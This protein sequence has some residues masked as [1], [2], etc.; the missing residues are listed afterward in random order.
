MNKT[1]SVPGFYDALI[2][3]AGPAG[4]SAAILLAKAGWRVLVVEKTRFPRRKVCGEYI[5]GAA[6]PL[7]DELGVGARIA[8]AA[9]PEIRRVG[10]FADDAVVSSLMPSHGLR[11]G[12]ALGREHLDTM[13][14]QQARECGATVLEGTAFDPAHAQL[15]H[16]TIA[17]HGAW[18]GNELATSPAHGAARTRDLL[19]F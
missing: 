16:V 1:G 15:A 6:W 18:E 13:L 3:G 10:L 9:G 19:G 7:L 4:S 17:A 11:H 8:A 2:V 14:A 5:S 12:R